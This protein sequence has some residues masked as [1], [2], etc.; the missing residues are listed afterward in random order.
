MASLSTF[1]KSLAKVVPRIYACHTRFADHKTTSRV[2]DA[3]DAERAAHLDG[4]EGYLSYPAEVHRIKGS[5]LRFLIG[6]RD[7]GYSAV[8]YGA[9]AAATR[10]S[11]TAVSVTIYSTTPLTP[12]HTS[13]AGSC[14][15]PADSVTPTGSA[16]PQTHRAS[17]RGS[18]PIIGL[19][20]LTSTLHAKGWDIC[21]VALS[22]TIG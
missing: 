7:L 16:A 15:A 5:L 11:T 4:L 22:I 8:A 21:S 9:R 17:Q 19:P 18:D 6:R 2:R 12:V 3:E 13:K 10:C 14:R 1:T 20:H